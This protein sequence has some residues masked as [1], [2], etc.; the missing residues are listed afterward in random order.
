MQIH[1][2]NDQKELKLHG[3][4]T[5][6]LCL[7]DERLS[8]YESGSFLW[9]WH[10]EVELTLI[11]EGTIL[12]QINEATYCLHAGEA[13][14]CNANTLHAGHMDRGQDCV[15]FSVTF[16]PR[17]LYGF[18]NSLLYTHYVQTICED[19]AFPSLCFC[20][21][22]PWQKEVI[23]AMYEIYSIHHHGAV[24]KEL[25]LQILL[26]QIWTKIFEHRQTVPPVPLSTSRQRE[27]IRAILSYI[28]ANYAEKITLEDIAS[29]IN[30]CKSECCR[31]F[32]SQM[33]E[34][35][36][37]YLLS[38][39]IE[40]SLPL[41]SGT[42]KSIT[43]IAEKTGFSN[44]CYFTKIFRERKGCSP[45]EYRKKSSALSLS[46]PSSDTAAASR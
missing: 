46:T 41:L 25:K 20:P 7:S 35:L 30:L 4:Y 14:F 2:N 28:H 9:H 39:R 15:Y 12:Y 37:N 19:P 32:K 22:V 29:S 1:T 16:H 11:V 31:L 24:A 8:S 42:D 3:D 36:F 17:L 43:E 10:P 27:R 23:D 44:P 13:L 33:K 21:D 26:L 34:S 40:Q 45:S 38:F 6:P 18:E 5:F